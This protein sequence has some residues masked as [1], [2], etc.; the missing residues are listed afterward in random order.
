MTQQ[1]FVWQS[2]YTFDAINFCL[3]A[4]LWKFHL[5]FSAEINVG[6]GLDPNPSPKLMYA[7]AYSM[8]LNS[9]EINVNFLAG[10]IPLFYFIRLLVALKLNKSL[11][12]IVTTI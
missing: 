3:F 4:Y 9:S 5:Q 1:M 11:G 8:N 10:I 2:T 7:H 12:P 6:L